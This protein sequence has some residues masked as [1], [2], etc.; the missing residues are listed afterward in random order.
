MIKKI[1]C[2][3]LFISN[4]GFANAFSITA[5]N[6]FRKDDI[7]YLKTKNYMFILTEKNSKALGVVNYK[8]KKCEHVKL[9][10][11][12]ATY[13]NNKIEFKDSFAMFNNEKIFYE[14]FED[15]FVKTDLIP[16][17]KIC[18]FGSIESDW[19]EKS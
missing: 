5:V 16:Y 11:N 1:I 18:K 6:E 10:K 8:Q 17:M 7:L 12:S 9:T 4:I 19:V 15:N 14:K 3:A 13:K 2:I